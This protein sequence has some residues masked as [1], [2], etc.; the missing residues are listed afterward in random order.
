MGSTR[1]EQAHDGELIPFQSLARGALRDYTGTASAG[2]TRTG[3]GLVE[4]P[5]APEDAVLR[6]AFSVRT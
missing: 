4:A 5:S 3:R 1:R 6:R 2:W